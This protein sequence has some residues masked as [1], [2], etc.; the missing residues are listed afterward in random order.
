MDLIELLRNEQ[1]RN[2]ER[3]ELCHIPYNNSSGEGLLA[4]NNHFQTHFQPFNQYECINCWDTRQHQ[5]QQIINSS[6][7]PI[8]PAVCSYC[9]CEFTCKSDLIQH[10]RMVHRRQ[11]DA[12][13]SIK[14]RICNCIFTDKL[15]RR[16]HEKDKHYDVVEKMYKC[17]MCTLKFSIASA[18]ARHQHQTHYYVKKDRRFECKFCG[19]WFGWHHNL[20]AHQQT[21]GTARPFRCDSCGANFKTL[22]LCKRHIRRIHD[23]DDVCRPYKCTKCTPHRQFKD[24]SDLRRHLWTHGGYAKDFKCTECGKSFYENK[25]LQ[26]HMRTHFKANALRSNVWA[27]FKDIGYVSA[28]K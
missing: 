1:L 8:S 17:T 19:K 23:S 4:V 18:V 28:Q 15:Q 2:I 5:P 6:C 21:H 13:E 20:M 22:V 14:C 24:Y 27:P 11:S 7:P 25:L 10:R 26:R 3:C 9:A 16:K 12:N